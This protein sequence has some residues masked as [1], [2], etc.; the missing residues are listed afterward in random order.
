[1]RKCAGSQLRP[2]QVAAA[3][4]RGRLTDAIWRDD[5]EA[6]RALLLEHPQLL[7]E[8]AKGCADSNWEPYRRLCAVCNCISAGPAVTRA[9]RGTYSDAGIRSSEQLFSR[10]RATERSRRRGQLVQQKLT[11]VVASYRLKAADR[12]RIDRAVR[13]HRVLRER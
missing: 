4:A 11:G 12:G 6:V 3:G 7:H 5:V 10:E 8:S 2:H 9:P 13:R 1:R